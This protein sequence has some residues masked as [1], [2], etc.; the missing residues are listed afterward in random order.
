[1]R[2]DLDGTLTRSV[3]IMDGNMEQKLEA[4]VNGL[5]EINGAPRPG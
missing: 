1:M 5:T 2:D 3:S 4:P